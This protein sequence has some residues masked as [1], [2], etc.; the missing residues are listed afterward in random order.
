[1]NTIGTIRP[2]DALASSK[3]ERRGN[4]LSPRDLLP[5]PLAA[6][7]G[8]DVEQL[9]ERLFDDVSVFRPEA[10]RTRC[11]C[12]AAQFGGGRRITMR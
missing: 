12:S 2:V 10:K 1:M 4:S 8:W 5:L 6:L 9:G 11:P 7:P 3:I